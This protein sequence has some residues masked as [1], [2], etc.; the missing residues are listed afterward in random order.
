MSLFGAFADLSSS[1]TFT[2]PEARPPVTPTV[3]SP[4]LGGRLLE[5]GGNVLTSIF[6]ERAQREQRRA[7]EA[8]FQRP[9]F[10]GRPNVITG[11]VVPTS[12]PFTLQQAG[13]VQ[14]LPQIIRNPAVQGAVGGLLGGLLGNELNEPEVINVAP[15]AIATRRGCGVAVGSLHKITPSG[16]IAPN[17]VALMPDGAGGADFFVHAGCPT[18]WSKVSIKKRRSACRPR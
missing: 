18:A 17:K 13:F 7:M 3:S 4:G 9:T 6:D 2:R 12:G 8:A 5:I 10:G 11:G 15:G 16:R 14:S 1:F